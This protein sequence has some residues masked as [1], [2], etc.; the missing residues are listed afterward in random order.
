LT[1]TLTDGRFARM[2]RSTREEAGGLTE[3]EKW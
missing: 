2:A 3:E 1:T